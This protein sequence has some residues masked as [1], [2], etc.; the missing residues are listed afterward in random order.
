MKIRSWWMTGAVALSLAAASVPTQAL[1]PQLF[2]P[3]WV[4]PRVTIAAPKEGRTVL[5]V[6]PR[7]LGGVRYTYQGA[8]RSLNDFVGRAQVKSLL[9]LHN[10]QIVHEHHRAPFGPESLHQSWS[11]MKQMLSALI[12]RAVASGAIRSIDDPM[13]RYAPALK[14]NGFAGVTFRQALTMSSGVRY[15]EEVDRVQLFKTV[16]AQRY[17]FGVSGATLDAET[18]KPELDRAYPPGSKYEYASINSQALAMALEGATGRQLRELLRQ[19]IW[20]PLGMP[21]DARLLTDGEGSEFGLCCLYATAR[22]Y[23]VFGQ[24]FAQG[25]QWNG[26]ALLPAD[27]V[28]RATSFDDPASW[29]S[30]HVP[31]TAKTQ[32]LFG[33]GYHWWPLEGPRGDFTALGIHG[34]LVYV[35]PRQNIVVVR[36]SDD[37]EPGAHNEESIAL[38]R[39]VVDHLS[40]G[41]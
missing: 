32:E 26:R 21:D 20:E 24:W 34:Q 17:T 4:L 22:S 11:V 9:V 33:F 18:L 16:I 29:H 31:R 10:G 7:D 28:R 23:A 2:K 3:E 19:E 30:V 13:D 36:L 8:T 27:W 14:A 5:P 35:S 25:G 1:L 6:S 41:R 12:G 15:D 39:A 37:Y 38:A 40:A